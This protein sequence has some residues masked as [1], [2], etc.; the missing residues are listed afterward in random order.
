MNADGAGQTRLTTSPA[1]DVAPA[2]SAD[3]LR[4]YFT[5]PRDGNA[6]LYVTNANGTPQTRLTN[7][8]AAD[9]LASGS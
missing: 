6:E 3:G 2:F 8:P 9:S 4:I 5:S 1:S 7:N